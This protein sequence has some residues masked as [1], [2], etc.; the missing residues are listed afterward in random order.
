MI[1]RITLT[2]FL[3]LMALIF[4]NLQASDPAQIIFD[5][6]GCTSYIE[7]RSYADYSEF[8]ANVSNTADIQLSV[9]NDHLYR[10]GRFVNKH[11]CTPSFNGSEAMCVSYDD[12]CDYTPGTDRAVRFDVRVNPT[13]DMPATLANLK[14]YEV[15]PLN[16]DWID[17][18]SGINNYPNFIAIRVLVNGA[19]VYEE[20]DIPTTNEWTLR[21]INFASLEAFT[22]VEPTVF[23]FE[24]SA[25]CPEG[26]DARVSVWDVDEI[27]LTATCMTD[28]CFMDGEFV[29]V[30]GG[31]LQGGPFSFCVD[32]S[33]DQLEEDAISLTDNVGPNSQWVVTDLDGLILGLPPTF[34]APDFDAAGAGTCLIWHLSYAGEVSGLAAGAN[35]NDLVGCFSLSNP[36][37]VERL[38]PE[39]GQLTGGPFE[40]TVGDG[41]VDNLDE[42]DIS[43]TGN[44]GANSQW[45]VTDDEGYILGLP[46]MPS[47]VD[48]DGAGAGTCLVWHLSYEGDIEGLEG[49]LGVED[50]QGC[51]SLS[52][53]VEVIRNLS[54]DC[55]VNGGELIG[56][57]FEFIVGDGE[58]DMISEENITL[59]NSQGNSQWIVTDDQG[60]ILGLPPTFSAVNF[61]GAGA[62]TCL[63]WHLSF[64]GEISGL[65]VGENANDLEGCFGLSNSI[66]V[67]RTNAGD[68][69]ANG[70]EIFGGPFE[71]TAGD[72]VADMIPEGA[73]TVANSNGANSQWIITDDEGN[74]LGL[75]PTFT[76]PNFDGAGAGTC[77]VWYLR[78]DGEISGLAVGENANDLEGCFGLS[79]SIEVVRTN[80]GDCQANGGEI[81][82]GPFAFTAGDGEADMIPEGAITVANSNGANSQW[83]ITDESGEILGLPG[84]FSDVDFDGA[85]A[86]TCLVWY[87]RYDGEISGLEMGANAN[88]LEGCFGLSNAIEVVRNGSQGTG[89][90]AMGVVISEFDA[91]GNVEL[92]NFGSATV[93]VSSYIL[94]NFPGYDIISRLE[95]VCGEDLML[96]EGESVTVQTDFA[97][98]PADGEL[99]LYLNN[100][101][102]NPS[103]IIDY[104][105]FGESGHRRSGTA[106]EAGIWTTGDFIPTFDASNSI[107]YDGSGESSSDYT[108][109]E[110]TI[111]TGENGAA[112]PN[113]EAVSFLINPTAALHQITI[114][115]EDESVNVNT[116]YIYDQTG[117]VVKQINYGSVSV[118]QKE[119][120]VDITDLRGGLY[121]V[122][123]IN[124]KGATTIRRFLKVDQ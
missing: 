82:G 26:I 8:T 59:A 66:E 98:N 106:Q 121:F 67:V 69:Q 43:L 46:P 120:K 100:S 118:D 79:N 103:S 30:D 6:D 95:I 91:S 92:T 1:H 61:D 13:G 104:L 38:Q 55:Q 124:D 89:D 11:S 122:Q 4:N 73:I 84:S 90:G 102:S 74:I 17:G 49:G 70:G 110:S 32:G 87:L 42:D 113:D 71:F 65:A 50:L 39:G 86:G 28:P 114:S 72:G 101:Y 53:P 41:L 44:S 60:Y 81:F 5:L 36:V 57:P 7:D 58:A 35:T 94:C 24:L 68:C 16:F 21:N 22:V 51:Y 34:S 33:V 96:E 78:Y 108:E 56:G 112:K 54:G 116:A 109:G 19:V 20:F 80:A 52:N 48:F 62:G 45:I 18:D 123:I 105:E 107:K 93:N 14:F 64:D 83:I 88:D 77:L 117:N 15:A 76:A 27:K 111:C 3:C 10:N 12:S 75:P 119:L 37:T 9:V 97:I 47:V 25:Y 99:G 115:I 2:T 85:G 23:N 31:F 63:I 40:F 29:H